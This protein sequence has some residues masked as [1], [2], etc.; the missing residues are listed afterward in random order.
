M[1]NRY[2]A[3]PD[4][5]AQWPDSVRFAY[6]AAYERLRTRQ[7]EVLHKSTPRMPRGEWEYVARQVALHV[8]ALIP[9]P[10]STPRA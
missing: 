7:N 9:A 3:P 1:T 2:G 6:E 5:W 4:L 8:A 10:E